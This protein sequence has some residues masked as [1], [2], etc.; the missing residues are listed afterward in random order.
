MNELVSESQAMVDAVIHSSW[1]ENL[2]QCVSLNQQKSATSLYSEKLK[3][4][5]GIIVFRIN[6]ASLRLRA[7]EK[8]TR[9]AMIPTV[10]K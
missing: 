6:A 10:S 1:L 4:P 5:N 3:I 8:L 2:S 7:A 9:P